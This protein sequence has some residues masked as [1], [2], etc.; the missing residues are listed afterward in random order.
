[1][2]DTNATMF[3]I[4][5]GGRYG[6]HHT[7]PGAAIPSFARRIEEFAAQFLTGATIQFATGIWEGASEPSMVI[8]TLVQD[9]ESVTGAERVERCALAAKR[10]FV[11]DSVLVTETRVKCSFL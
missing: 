7:D 1:M 2:P 6:S 11:Q 4:Y 3:S 8:Q 5:I 9:A 10:L